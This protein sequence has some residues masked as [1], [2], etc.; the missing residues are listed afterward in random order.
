MRSEPLTFSAFAR[1]RLVAPGCAASASSTRALSRTGAL[2]RA[3]F[4]GV[5][6]RGFGCFP[7]GCFFLGSFFVRFG[8]GLFLWL[9]FR[10]LGGRLR[11][12]LF[13]P[14]AAALRDAAP[15]SARPHRRA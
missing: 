3:P 1:S 2:P 9:G 5:L 6:L 10:L 11:R 15:R 14:F 13:L 7:L 12:F 4:F 8:F